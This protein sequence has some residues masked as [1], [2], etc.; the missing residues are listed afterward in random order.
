MDK[1]KIISFFDRLSSNWDEQLETDGNKINTILDRAGVKKGASVLDVACGTGVL[2]PFYLERG[3]KRITGVDISPKMVSLAKSKFASFPETDV[4]NADAEAYSFDKD[5]DCCMVFNAFPHFCN[6]K[7]LI[8]NLKSALKQGGTLTV[9]HDRGRKALDSH[10]KSEA[11]EVSQGLMSET[12][13]AAL[14][15]EC[16]FKNIFTKAT[17]EIY[18]VT[19]TK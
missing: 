5:Y 16:G 13:L 1:Q 12:E 2:F 11:A 10:H 17:D 18:I 19:G 15:E 4:I 6:P 8:I 7:G 14:F 9:A 3:V